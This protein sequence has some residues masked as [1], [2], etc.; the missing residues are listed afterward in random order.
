MSI[1]LWQI[2]SGLGVGA[3]IAALFFGVIKHF[4]RAEGKGFRTSRLGKEATGIIAVLIILIFGGITVLALVLYAPQRGASSPATLPIPPKGRA[5][6]PPSMSP[7]S[8]AR[9][10]LNFVDDGDYEGS[11]DH[12]SV[13]LQEITDKFNW[14]K[15]LTEFRKPLGAPTDRTVFSVNPWTKKDDHT[16]FSQVDFKTHFQTDTKPERFEHIE[17]SAIDGA[18]PGVSAYRMLPFP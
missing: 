2:A 6:D 14:Q 1:T 12:S 16:Y 5:V 8:A 13:R 10:W 4:G 17:L 9:S 18:S 7:V 11:W 15:V 3:F